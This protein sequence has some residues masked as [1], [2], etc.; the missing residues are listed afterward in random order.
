M[1]RDTPEQVRMC[2]ECPHK[3]CINCLE[4]KDHYKYTKRGKEKK[5]EG[6]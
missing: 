4:N 3:K 6:V 5:N 1:K 2:L